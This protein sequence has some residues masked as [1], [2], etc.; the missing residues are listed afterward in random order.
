[1]STIAETMRMVAADCETD[2]AAIDGTPF[3]AKG[4]GETIGATLAMLHAVASAVAVIAD[5][6]EED[7]R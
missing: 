4:V 5:K 3:T 6:L 2:A 7:H 1:M